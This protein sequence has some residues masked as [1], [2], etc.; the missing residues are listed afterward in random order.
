MDR[1]IVAGVDPVK[2]GEHGGEVPAEDIAGIGVV[3]LAPEG[4]DRKL[5]L[6][7][8]AGE[9][10][11]LQQSLGDQA[12]DDL[13][14]IAARDAEAGGDRRHVFVPLFV[15]QQILQHLDLGIGIANAPVLHFFDLVRRGVNVAVVDQ[16]VD[17]VAVLSHPGK[18]HKTTS[19][20]V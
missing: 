6:L 2:L 8:A 17:N 11:L 5:Q 13:G 4:V 3:Q 20:R 18:L 12:A 16:R 7:A 15:F 14:E 10:I 9:I 19:A 1:R